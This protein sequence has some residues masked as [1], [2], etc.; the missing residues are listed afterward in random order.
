MAAKRKCLFVP[1]FV[2]CYNC[3]LEE[4]PMAKADSALNENWG[5]KLA[6]VGS[7]TTVSR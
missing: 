6:G 5:C 2:Y 4:Q 1:P 3:T 7:R